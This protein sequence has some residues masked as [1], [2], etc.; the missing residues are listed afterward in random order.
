MTKKT[1]TPFNVIYQDFNTRKFE[2]YD[3]MPYF[4]RSWE[5]L[6][7]SKKDEIKTLENLKNWFIKES[8]YM[9]WARCQYEVVLQGW[10][11]TDDT[12]KIDIHWQI[13][14]NIDLIVRIFAENIKFKEK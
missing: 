8:M 1:M 9:F 5:G 6:T 12:K 11:N 2:A 13:M 10:P 14:M 3:I 4:I 7:K